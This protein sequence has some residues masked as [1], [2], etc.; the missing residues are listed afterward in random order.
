[1]ILNLTAKRLK[2]YLDTSIPN[3]LFVKDYRL[4]HTVKFWEDCQADKYEI[5]VAPVFFREL[6]LCPEPQLGMMYEKL[7]L[8][9][10]THL[11][12]TEEAKELANL[13]R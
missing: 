3:A 12:E 4:D 6:D 10:F 13:Y 2:L 8:I 9:K 11:I 7:N 5:F 1:M